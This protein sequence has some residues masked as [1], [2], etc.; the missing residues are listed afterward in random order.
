M[1]Y[2]VGI[3]AFTKIQF[4]FKN[5]WEIHQKYLRNTS[6]VFEKYIKSIW[7]IH[8]QYLRNT[9]ASRNQG[10][11]PPHHLFH[12][13][14]NMERDFF[15]LPLILQIFL[16]IVQCGVC[17]QLPNAYILKPGDYGAHG[18]RFLCW[19]PCWWEKGPKMARLSSILKKVFF[20]K[21]L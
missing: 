4:L 3:E 6:K 11:P 2:Q 14:G 9:A 20:G 7:E 16:H 18:E 10:E 17:T 15:S 12:K 1:W 13:F 19:G 5:V 21:P 8:Q